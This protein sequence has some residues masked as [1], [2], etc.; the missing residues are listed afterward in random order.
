MFTIALDAMGGDFAPSHPVQGA[1]LALKTLPVKIILVGPK[2]KLDVPLSD[3]LSVVDAPDVVAMAEAPSISYKRKPRSSIRVGLD[4]VKEGKAHAFVSAGN[5]GAVMFASTFILGRLENVERPAIGGILPTQLGTALLLDMG[6]TVDCR[7]NHLCQFAT[8]GFHYAKS[9]M[10]VKHPKVA[11]LNIGEEADKGNHLSLATYPLLEK[12]PI[13][14]IG[15]IEGKEV[16]TGKA[17]VIVCDG[18]VGNNLLKFGEGAS[19][20]FLDFFR[21]ESKRSLS[22]KLG[23]MLLKPSLKRFLKRFDYDET[24]GAPLLGLNGVSIIAH[25]SASPLAIKNAIRTAVHALENHMVN[26]IAK[27]LVQ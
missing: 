14:F 11:L 4:L 13:N 26:K 10:D 7:P 23:L 25:G 6:S 22:S 9:V 8:M 1:L 16:L 21:T 24:G 5:T 12:L 15:N 2:N 19:K 20:L 18:F 17:D 27:A 3:R